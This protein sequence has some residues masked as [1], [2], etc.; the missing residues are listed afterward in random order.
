MAL[1]LHVPGTIHAFGGTGNAGALEELGVSEDGVTMSINTKYQPV[2]TD[3]YGPE[4]P[5][6]YQIFLQD[7]DIE[8]PLIWYEKTV[9]YK[10]LLGAPA[11][12]GPT[13]GNMGFAGDLVVQNGFAVRLLLKV[14]PPLAGGLTGVEDCWNFP[15]AILMEPAKVKLGVKLN[16]WNLKFKALLNQQASSSLGAVLFNFLCV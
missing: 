4:V 7:V 3:H 12:P 10:W 6:D 13:I 8:I 15:R 1:Q 9:L 5:Y 14:T 2:Y 11:Q 16:P